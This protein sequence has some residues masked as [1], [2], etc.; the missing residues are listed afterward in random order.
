MLDE[1]RR[2]GKLDPEFEIE[3]T[4]IFKED[5]YFDITA[6][7]AKHDVDDILIRVT[8]ANRGPEAADLL[9]LPTLWFR[10]TW[11]WCGPPV[12]QQAIAQHDLI[13]RG[14]GH[15]RDTRRISVDA[16]RL[17]GTDLH[18]ERDE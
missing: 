12:S 15:A 16:R 3:D 14:P 10:N 5:R 1:N 6:E 17:A 4:G 2:R 8:I 13:R 9:F 7:Y 18:G 11:V